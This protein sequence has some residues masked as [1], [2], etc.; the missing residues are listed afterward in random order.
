ML[1]GSVTSF[2]NEIIF[3]FATS[4]FHEGNGSFEVSFTLKSCLIILFE[5]DKEN[6]G[7]AVT[8]IKRTK[9]VTN[10]TNKINIFSVNFCLI[11]LIYNN[12]FSDIF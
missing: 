3:C 12:L 10:Y 9:D 2:T 6:E 4:S 8:F 11:T 7:W 5:L 1:F